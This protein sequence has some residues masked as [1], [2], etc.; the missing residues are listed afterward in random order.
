MKTK[1]MAALLLVSG[2]A[3]LMAA[4]VS[5]SKDE[6]GET[7]VDPGARSSDGRP[8]GQRADEERARAAKRS[9][10]MPLG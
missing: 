7:S 5:L 3:A 2:Y 8:R 10:P 6:A 4:T 1:V 9:K